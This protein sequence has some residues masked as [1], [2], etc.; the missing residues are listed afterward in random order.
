MEPV[1]QQ[2]AEAFLDGW[3]AR[4]SS[5]TAL[6]LKRFANTL[7]AH[8]K[9]ITLDFAGSVGYSYSDDDDF[10]EVNDDDKYQN[11]GSSD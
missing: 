3:I 11:F 9:G 1:W 8:K 5:S 2:E 4:A 6:M 7:A 10:V